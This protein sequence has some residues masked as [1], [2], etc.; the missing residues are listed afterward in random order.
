MRDEEWPALPDESAPPRYML[1]SPAGVATGSTGPERSLRLLLS[2]CACSIALARWEEVEVFE[3]SGGLLIMRRILILFLQCVSGLES[4][5]SLL[6]EAPAVRIDV[7]Q[8]NAGTA[9]IA[10]SLRAQSRSS[11][12]QL[13]IAKHAR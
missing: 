5:A 3:G 13:P 8:R 1:L 9:V 7:A 12:G 2:P 4:R 10:S 11:Q 6:S